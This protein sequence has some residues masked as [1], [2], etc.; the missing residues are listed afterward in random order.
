MA[1]LT[2]L[3]AWPFLFKMLTV[4]GLFPSEIRN[5]TDSWFLLRQS[6]RRIRPFHLP[7]S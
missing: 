2:F 4:A 6:C 3:A 7:L 1:M 5:Y